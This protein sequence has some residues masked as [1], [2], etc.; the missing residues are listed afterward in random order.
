MRRAD[1]PRARVPPRFISLMR[2]VGRYIKGSQFI[3]EQFSGAAGGGQPGSRC[4]SA[5]PVRF[6]FVAAHRTRHAKS[7]PAR[8]TRGDADWDSGLL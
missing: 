8:S 6:T 2:H 5:Y 4:R 1:Q 3:I 7:S